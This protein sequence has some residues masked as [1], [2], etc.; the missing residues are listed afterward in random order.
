M[1]K[2]STYSTTKNAERTKPPC[3]IGRLGVSLRGVIELA[4]EYRDLLV[5]IRD[6]LGSSDWN[7]TDVEEAED[8]LSS[9]KENATASVGSSHLAWQ[10]MGPMAQ[11]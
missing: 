11:G 1:R 9:L 4:R 10:G 6:L 5:E 3:P 8:Y 7:E 2:S